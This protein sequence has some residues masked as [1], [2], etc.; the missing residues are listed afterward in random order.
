MDK[1]QQ[2]AYFVDEH[3]VLRYQLHEADHVVYGFIGF[4]DTT[5]EHGVYPRLS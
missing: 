3:N 5:N 2:S 4:N 1:S